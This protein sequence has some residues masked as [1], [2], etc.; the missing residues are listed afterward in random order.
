MRRFEITDAS[1]T[2]AGIH[3]PEAGATAD[4]ELAYTLADGVEYIRAGLAAG[5]TQPRMSWDPNAQ[6]MALEAA[7]PSGRVSVEHVINV[8]GRLNA[9][10]LPPNAQTQLRVSDPP[11]ANTARYDRLRGEGEPEEID[12]A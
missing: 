7:P 2:V 5:L 12:H 1:R 6:K 3:V 8:I 9:P 4:L 10:P 11:L